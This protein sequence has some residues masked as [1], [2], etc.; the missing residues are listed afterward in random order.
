ME[1]NP[2]TGRFKVSKLVPGASVDSVMTETGFEPEVSGTIDKVKAP[3]ADEL[4]ILR[5]ECDPNGLYFK[6]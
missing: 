4:R 1:T 6:S 5:E 3:T 2:D